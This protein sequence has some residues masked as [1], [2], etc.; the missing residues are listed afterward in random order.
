MWKITRIYFDLW[1][2]IYRTL[3]DPKPFRGR[4]ILLDRFVKSY[5][6]TRHV[7]L[8]DSENY[9]A[10]YDEIRYCRSLKSSIT[11]ICF[12]LL[13]DNQSRFLWFFTYRKKHWDVI[14]HINKDQ[15][16]YSY[17]IFLEKRSYQLAK[18]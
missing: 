5:D 14:I 9:A 6:E 15:N 1:N 7:L 11:Y 18:K 3:I 13:N 17:N 4:F 12:S 2:L 16:L 10:I 8:F